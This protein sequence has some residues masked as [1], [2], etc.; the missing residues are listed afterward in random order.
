MTIGSNMGLLIT[1]A[2][3]ISWAA[4]SPHIMELM[5]LVAGV[6][7]FGISRGVFRYGERYL[8]HKTALHILGK[9]RLNLY[10]SL[11]SLSPGQ[12]TT[13]H[14]GQL[15]GRL[16][17]DI[18]NLKEVYLRVFLPPIVAFLIFVSTAYLLSL[19]HQYLLLNFLIFY[20]LA[21]FG[22][23]YVT[24]LVYKG[25][26][27][28]TD[29]K[30]VLNMTLVDSIRGLTE[31]LT[32]GRT[33]E[34]QQKTVGQNSKFVRFKL[35]FAKKSA[36]TNSLIQLLNGLTLFS[37]LLLGILLINT[38]KLKAIWLAPLVLGVQ[39]SFEAV[40]GLS[41]LVPNIRE[42]LASAK[43]IF[44]IEELSPQKP[45]PVNDGNSL[46]G[47]H[48]LVV[49][50]LSFTYPD[51]K[52]PAIQ[53]I[54]FN[55]NEGK[56]LG[57]VGA[58]GS[59]K[60]TISHLLLKFW[61]YQEGTITLGGKDLNSIPENYLWK[62]IGLVSR[63]TYLFNATLRENLLLAKSTATEQELL[64]A[65]D[66]AQFKPH[67]AQLPAGLE[68]KVGEGGRKLSGG[69][70]QLI[71][72]ARMIL[73]DPTILILDEATEGLDPI[74]EAQALDAIRSLMANRSII[75]ITHKLTNLNKMDEIIFLQEG[76]IAERG[77]HQELLKE[78]NF[79][80]RYYQLAKS[81]HFS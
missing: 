33:K 73:K 19:F 52:Q 29:T 49:S 37:T 76:K 54:N 7:F 53:K 4:L 59:G 71:A 23:A 6:R 58:I 42:S 9:I 17:G 2:Y 30:E 68:T 31:L 51:G 79:Y 60:S 64:E 57:I 3:L 46:I 15:L 44:A 11:E 70:R 5:T 35:E 65:L 80:Y 32:S 14:S 69:Q 1:S 12:L 81:Y 40:F 66:L 24:S 28:L 26:T 50:N 78:Q 22:V 63:Q 47:H 72:L 36:L 56:H 20:F 38:G 34:Y 18:E 55:L 39:A 48:E 10:Q 75:M 61:D 25:K 41:Q 77:T 8:N 67:L 74:T 16:L 43:R 13:L 62:T 21:T 45:R 27:K